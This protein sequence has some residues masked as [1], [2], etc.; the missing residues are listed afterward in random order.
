MDR[1]LQTVLDCGI[2]LRQSAVFEDCIVARDKHGRFYKYDAQRETWFMLAPSYIRVQ[3]R[4]EPKRRP[5]L[6]PRKSR[7]VTSE[8][9]VNEG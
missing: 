5:S 6:K 2:D 8:R 7:I 3:Q 1:F 4:R 9:P